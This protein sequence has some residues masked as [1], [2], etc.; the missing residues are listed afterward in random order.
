MTLPPGP[1]GSPLFGCLDEFR[2]DPTG[3][4]ARNAARYGDV[5]RFRMAHLPVYQFTHPDAVREIL[6]D[7]NHVFTKGEVLAGF[8]PLIGKGI[9][10]SEGDT[11]RRQRRMMQPAFHRER[12][13]AYGEAMLRHAARVEGRWAPGASVD[14]AAE[15]AELTL[16]I[17]A[18][19]LFGADLST[20]DLEVVRGAMSTFATW[21]HQSTHPLGAIL[22]LLPLEGTRRFKAAKASL[23]A[24]VDRIVAERRAGEDRGDILSMLVFARDADGDGAAMDD[25]HVHDEAVTL[26]VAGHETTAAALTWAWALLAEHPEVHAR[27][28]AEVEER[29]AG[30]PLTAAD[31]RR[32]PYTT[33]VFAEALRL[34]PVAPGMPRVPSRDVEVAGVRVPRGAIVMLSTWVTHHDPRWWP[35]PLAFR[36]ERWSAEERAK[37]PKFS[38]FGFGGGARVCIG[39]AFAWMEGTLVLAELSRRWRPERV[40]RAPI[41]MESLFTL[42]PKGGLPMILRPSGSNGAPTR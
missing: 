16:T 34:Y 12:V 33:G 9:F 39:E 31:A 41:E 27:M 7:S 17:A 28:C 30:S 29:C 42:R 40:D 5:V 36:P 19:T 8:R 4:A 37:R 21:Y 13:E 15:M 25:A 32:L 14:M 11:H 38:F 23:D 2:M 35:E 18:E 24:L 20:A 3:F 26:L 10:L 6:L 22:Q 1:T